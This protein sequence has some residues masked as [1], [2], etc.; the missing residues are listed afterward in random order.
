M[1]PEKGFSILDSEGQI[2]YDQEANAALFESLQSNILNS[3]KHR[4]IS[5]P[6]HINDPSFADA[7]AEAWENV[8]GEKL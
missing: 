2:F 5:L 1:F 4:L 3:H 7:L 8:V 6:M